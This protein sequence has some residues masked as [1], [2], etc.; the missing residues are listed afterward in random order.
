TTFQTFLKVN[1]YFMQVCSTFSFVTV[2]DELGEQ[3]GKVAEQL[4]MVNGYFE[5]DVRRT[6]KKVLTMLEPLILVVFGGI[7]A[8]ILLS[9]FPPMYMAMGQMK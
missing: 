9:T 4:A 3:T 1:P 5:K 6:T 7:S 2:K 8:V